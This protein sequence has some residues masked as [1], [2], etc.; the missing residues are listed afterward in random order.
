M[1]ILLAN[2]PLKSAEKHEGILDVLLTCINCLG[3]RAGSAGTTTQALWHACMP[4]EQPMMSKEETVSNRCYN[5]MQVMPL[6]A[7][8]S[9]RNALVYKLRSPH[10]AV[11]DSYTSLKQQHADSIP[12][13]YDH[14]AG[15]TCDL[16]CS[17]SAHNIPYHAL[18][19]FCYT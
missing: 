2:T 19:P 9:A 11:L 13:R 12:V 5:C 16:F 8:S 17:S 10:S 4:D 6:H 14:N 15:Q 18:L 7:A 1:Y 3:I